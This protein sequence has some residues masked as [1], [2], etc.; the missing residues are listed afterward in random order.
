MTIINVRYLRFMERIR[1]QQPVI[2]I[3]SVKK[4]KT[5]YVR[6]YNDRYI[7]GGSGESQEVV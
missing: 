7:S 6:L 5:T 2:C 3:W 1:I 4:K